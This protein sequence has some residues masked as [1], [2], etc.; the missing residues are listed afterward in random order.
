MKV[1]SVDFINV[2]K[3]GLR[4]LEIVPKPICVIISDL[5]KSLGRDAYFRHKV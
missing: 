1:H 2:M 3:L 5:A 4:E